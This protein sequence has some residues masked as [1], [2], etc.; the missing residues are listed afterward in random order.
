[1][2]TINKLADPKC[3]YDK[4]ALEKEKQLI[5]A[6]AQKVFREVTPKEKERSR[7]LIQ[8]GM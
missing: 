1:M 4:S 7:E 8:V 6:L 3:V 5:M 2:G